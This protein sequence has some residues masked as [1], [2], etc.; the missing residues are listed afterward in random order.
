MTPTGEHCERVKTYLSLVGLTSALLFTACGT[1]P[2]PGGSTP[3]SKPA[4][5]VSGKSVFISGLNDQMYGNADISVTLANA[6]ATVLWKLSGGEIT[7]GTTAG[8]AVI[9]N[10]TLNQQTLDGKA[11]TTITALDSNK[12]TLATLDV[13]IDDKAPTITVP[14]STDLSQT[15]T[16]LTISASDE[17]SGLNTFTASCTGGTTGA[18][19][20]NCGTFDSSKGTITF[21]QTT[22][23]KQLGTG[24]IN[25][26]LSATDKVGNTV[27]TCGFA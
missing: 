1:L 23:L 2:L 26:S 14:D 10:S 19:V 6:P 9:P 18:T 27:T 20:S 5:S 7:P 15:A 3:S 8:Q 12:K 17:G 24:T 11:K 21:N 25:V 22:I 4:L 16:S 13:Y